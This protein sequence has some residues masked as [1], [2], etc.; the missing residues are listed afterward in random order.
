MNTPQTPPAFQR[1][2]RRATIW[3]AALAT[4]WQVAPALAAD[5]T[6]VNPIQRAHAPPPAA[7]A[8]SAVTPETA[9]VISIKGSVAQQL[10]EAIEKSSGTSGIR[11]KPPAQS[12]IAD[13][14]AAA[15]KVPAVAQAHAPAS[16]ASAVPA[17]VKSRPTARRTGGQPA[18]SRN[19]AAAP[20]APAWSYEGE[21]GPQAWGRLRPE[22]SLCANG[23]RQ[24]PIHIEAASAL[25][26]PAE[27]LQISYLASK[28][29]V[30]N[31]GYTIQVD[32]E[33]E[34]TLT[35]RGSTYKL[36]QFHFHHPAEEK[37]N[38][39]SFDL[40][41]HLVHKNAEGQMAVLA[42]LFNSGEANAM[43]QKVWTHMPLDVND[44]V[45][46]PDGLVD[47]NESLPQDRRY[48]QFM[49]SVTMP[50]C[51]EGVLWIVLKTPMTLTPDQLKVFARQFPNNARP[52]QPTFGRVVREAQ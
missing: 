31:T 30:V 41:A 49:G 28:G 34:N 21:T 33:G 44:R 47:L 6:L 3:L 24:S 4:M 37:I 20:P 8:A 48:Y 18:A 13:R 42:V 14:K 52:V 38:G 35:V 9:P 51:T 22:F 26:G 23:K 7:S 19:A 39:Q 45:R 50:P 29:A 10:R 1:A 36:E 32:L 40:V 43:I 5:A 25:Q 46:L 11:K 17:E 15:E 2:S 27:P 12:G 16:K